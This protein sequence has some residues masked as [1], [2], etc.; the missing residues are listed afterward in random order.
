MRG[1]WVGAMVKKVQPREEE[2]EELDAGRGKGKGKE[3]AEEPWEREGVEGEKEHAGRQAGEKGRAEGPPRGESASSREDRRERPRRPVPPIE[4]PQHANRARIPPSPPPLELHKLEKLLEEGPLPTSRG[5]VIRLLH[6]LP[7]DA[8]PRDFLALALHLRTLNLHVD[9]APT[10]LLVQA[11]IRRDEQATARRLLIAFV[12]EMEAAKRPAKSLV[13]SLESPVFI[14]AK[15]SQWNWVVKFTDVAINRRILSLELLKNRMHGLYEVKRYADV[16]R[17]FELF[18]QSGLEPDEEVLDELVCAHLKQANLA[19]AHEI[20]ALKSEQS[21][22][23]TERTVLAILDGMRG[24]HGNEGMENSI[25]DT[26]TTSQLVQ[27]AALRQ[28]VRVLNRVMSVRAERS[29]V[30]MA[31]AILEHF[32]LDGETKYRLALA[33]L[34]PS[35]VPGA[36]P[37]SDDW[38][39]P[40]PDIATFAVFMSMALRRNHAGE[41]LDLFLDS[42]R[43]GLGLNQHLVSHLVRTVVVNAGADKAEEFVFNL[44]TGAALPNRDFVLPS[45]EPTALVYETLFSGVLNQKGLR[46]AWAVLERTVAASEKKVAASEGIVAAL[47]KYLSLERGDPPKVSADFLVKMNVLTTG[48][49]KPT[50]ANLNDLV[51]AAWQRERFRSAANRFDKGRRLP[52]T[53]LSSTTTSSSPPGPPP[54]A[55]PPSSMSRVRHSLSHREVKKDATTVQLLL[56]NDALPTPAAMWEYIHTQLIARGARPTYHHITLIMR[57]Q[58]KRGDL[59]GARASLRRA[60]DL[61]V[62]P[63]PAFYSV[64][65]GWCSR[66][67]RPADVAILLM[68][69]RR[70]HVAPDRGLYLALA[71]AAARKRD[72]RGVKDIMRN[73]RG[74]VPNVSNDP[75]FVLILYRALVGSGKILAAQ[76]LLRRRLRAREDGGVDMMPDPAVAVVLDRTRRWFRRKDVA[77]V[78]WSK[79]ELRAKRYCAT[80]I[81]RVRRLVKEASG[82]DGLGD[83]GHVERF[84]DLVRFGRK[85]KGQRRARG[86]RRRAEARA[87]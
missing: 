29:Q 54:A 42:Q 34:V 40:P 16:V 7:L 11:A 69:M 49:R 72:V 21:L 45:F 47:V 75:V 79:P 83:L 35:H 63:H 84:L 87:A 6:N 12:R 3:R 1:F 57:A 38:W 15:L 39:R 19:A 66:L 43:L 41:G 2:L 26:F 86:M 50:L 60:L 64:L 77:G 23:T 70:E 14:L 30:V 53:T 51:K 36:R 82:K 61:G 13:A 68:E 67:G 17:T 25:L 33:S 59:D 37:L 56:R 48:A 24:F 52:S 32:D 78:V 27:R 46:G 8:R 22:P 20:L 55:P 5:D 28:N 65:I 10:A 81:R 76:V 71:M 74:V 9:V 62:E 58:L 73:A 4:P 85:T 31:L 44:S 18:A 80:N